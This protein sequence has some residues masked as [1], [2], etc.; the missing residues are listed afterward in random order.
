[1]RVATV[2]DTAI[3]SIVVVSAFDG[4]IHVS[5]HHVT[6]ETIFIFF[7]IFGFIKFQFY[8]SEFLTSSL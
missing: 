4:L 2:A 6:D 3:A 8:V 1:M 7:L 5:S